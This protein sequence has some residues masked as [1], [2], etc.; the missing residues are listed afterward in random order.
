MSQSWYN[1]DILKLS[2]DDWIAL[3]TDASVFDDEGIEMLLFVYAE[4]NHQSSATEIRYAMG[5]AS[6]QKITAINRTIAKRIYKKFNKE[7]PPN[8]NGGKRYWNCIFDG[9]KKH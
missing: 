4:S 1:Q 8:S 5:Q 6:H 7:A 2:K 3:L 9:D